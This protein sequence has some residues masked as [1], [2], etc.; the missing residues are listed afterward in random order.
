MFNKSFYNVV[1][2]VLLLLSSASFAFAQSIQYTNYNTEDG[3]P[4]P[5]TYFAHEDAKGYLWFGTDRGLSRYDGYKFTNFTTANSDLTNNTIF[6]CYEAPNTDLW[7]TCYDGSISIFDIETE[8]FRPFKFNDSLKKWFKYW[9]NEIKFFPESIQIFGS[10][11]LYHYVVLDTSQ[12][13]VQRNNFNDLELKMYEIKLPQKPIN[14]LYVKQSKERG[15][16]EVLAFANCIYCNEIDIILGKWQLENVAVISGKIYIHFDQYLLS[17]DHDVVK[18]EFEFKDVINYIYLDKSNR[19]YVLTRNGCYVKTQGNY[20]G[21]LNNFSASGS[22]KTISGDLWVTSL[23]KGIVRLPTHTNFQMSHENIQN[24]IITQIY[25]SSNG[26]LLG[27]NRETIFHYNRK[28]TF[29]LVVDKFTKQPGDLRMSNFNAS[30]SDIISTGGFR[31]IPNGIDFNI[32]KIKTKTYTS[33]TITLDNGEMMSLP[34]L[35][36][37]I[38]HDDKDKWDFVQTNGEQLIKVDKD[39]KG[40][41]WMSSL[42]GIWRLDQKDLYKPIRILDFQSLNDRVND[43]THFDWGI[44]AFSTSANGIVLVKNNAAYVISDSNGLISNMTNC[45]VKSQDTI[46]WVGTNKGISKVVIK[47]DISSSYVDFS[48]NIDDGLLSNYVYSICYWDNA[49]WVGTDKGL[50]KIPKENLEPSRFTPRLNISKMSMANSQ[51][52][53]LVNELNHK[54]NDIRIH[55]VGICF[56]K[57]EKD[58]YRYRLIRNGIQIEDYSFTDNTNVDF[59]K[60]IPGNYTFEIA[61]KNKNYVWSETQTHTFSIIPH[62]SQTDWFRTS[63]YLLGILLLITI[64]FYQVREARTKYNRENKLQTLE[65]KYQESELAALR[66]QMNP[67]FVFNALNSIQSYVLD[68]NIETASSYIQ[69]FSTLM[70]ESLEYSKCELILLTREI[71]F[72]KN[73]LRIEQLRFPKRFNYSV[74]IES[75]DEENEVMIPPLIIQPIVENCVKHAFE[76]MDS[77]GIVSVDFRI[78]NKTINCIVTD[79][80]IGIKNARKQTNIAHESIGIRVVENRLA[81]IPGIEYPLINFVDL[82]EENRNEHGTKAEIN[83]PII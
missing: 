73:Y 46:L 11:E 62:F 75:S 17:I 23:S 9:P 16:D 45:F 38:I 12:S 74:N 55:Y 49:L 32:E 54:Q 35:P 43:I 68:K 83:I 30:Q 56:K 20:Q 66:N 13:Y 31:F 81:L 51:D 18:I 80:G 36:G 50:L 28:E 6:K 57:P 67:H 8:K 61:C 2:V 1:Y 24:S 71:E 59:L 42:N 25:G 72:L 64:S 70:R 76:S 15:R 22:I 21:F 82:S 41:I 5:E 65:Y 27:T 39:N 3:L 77:G 37:Y 47:E 79:N 7:F 10:R 14:K 78:I 48:L 29:K 52:K 26:L 34:Y 40:V 58:F 33:Q 69:Q 63:L 60:L 19:L 4:S 53:L 44:N